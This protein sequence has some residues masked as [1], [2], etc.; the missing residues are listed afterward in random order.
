MRQPHP[1][2]Q[3]LDLAFNKLTNSSPAANLQS[4]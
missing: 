3:P 2:S 1:A 4:G